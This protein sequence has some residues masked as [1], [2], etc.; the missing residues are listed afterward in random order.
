[1][2][3][4]LTHE[5]A[6]QV[7]FSPT[8]HLAL[9]KGRNIKVEVLDQSVTGHQSTEVMKEKS[10]HVHNSTWTGTIEDDM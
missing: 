4:H 10:S 2:M 1:M 8:H 6:I 7:C 9:S 5:E 3:E